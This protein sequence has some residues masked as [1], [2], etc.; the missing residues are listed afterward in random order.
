M[1]TL[2]MRGWPGGFALPLPFPG[3]PGC[4]C[5]GPCPGDGANLGRGHLPPAFCWGD[6]SLWQCV[7]VTFPK[8]NSSH[9]GIFLLKPIYQTCNKNPATGSQNIFSALSK[10]R[11]VCAKMFLVPAAATSPRF[12]F[13]SS[14]TG[15]DDDCEFQGTFAEENA[16]FGKA[17]G[18][19]SPGDACAE[20]TGE[21]RW[22]Q[23]PCKGVLFHCRLFGWQKVPGG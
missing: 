12:R 11:W 10:A 5:W 22:S 6:I 18:L 2:G 8:E 19:L 4:S 1:E 3:P 14:W 23:S 16:N 13:S 9:G 20:P 21:Q 17:G 7:V 15:G